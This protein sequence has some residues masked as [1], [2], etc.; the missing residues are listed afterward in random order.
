MASS[1]PPVLCLVILPFVSSLNF[2]FIIPKGVAWPR[3]PFQI[4]CRWPWKPRPR[5]SA[6]TCTQPAL[7]RHDPRKREADRLRRPGS[8]G[9]SVRRNHRRPATQ[10]PQGSFLHE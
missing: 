4:G 9:Q 3:P 5:S 6:H 8:S 1:D 7:G 10:F 2:T